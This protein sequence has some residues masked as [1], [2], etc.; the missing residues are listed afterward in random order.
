MSQLCS[1]GGMITIGIE[2][3]LGLGRHQDTITKT[4]L[5]KFKHT[6]FV[7][8]LMSAIMGLNLVK[9][10]VSF[11]LMRFVQ[12]RWYKRGLWA[13]ISKPL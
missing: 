2:A 8:T 10:S 12:H 3:P 5:K 11:L 9:I 13:L 7:Y 1:I 6:N 4:N